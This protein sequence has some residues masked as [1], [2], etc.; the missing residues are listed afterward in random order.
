MPTSM[1][2]ITM[3]I[4]LICGHVTE[5]VLACAC[6]SS[7]VKEL[8]AW[9]AGAVPGERDLQGS[10]CTQICL[11]VKLRVTTSFVGNTHRGMRTEPAGPDVTDVRL[12]ASGSSGL[13]SRTAHDRKWHGMAFRAQL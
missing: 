11:H 8:S 5:A 4:C 7:A 12:P 3:R 2:T 13:P 1:P 6:A 10:A 9:P